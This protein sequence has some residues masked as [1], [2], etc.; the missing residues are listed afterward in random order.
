MLPSGGLDPVLR[1]LVGRPAKQNN[2]QMP[3]ELRERLFKFSEQ[4]ALDLASIDLQRGRDHG[5]PG[6]SP[7][8]PFSCAVVLC[9]YLFF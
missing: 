9:R 4:L 1:G 5:L 8:Q 2:M 7:V 3:D 6:T